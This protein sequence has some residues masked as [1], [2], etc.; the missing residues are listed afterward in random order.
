ME[1]TS[2][3]RPGWLVQLAQWITH[4]GE[5]PP[6]LAASTTRKG[7][8]QMPVRRVTAVH[9]TLQEAARHPQFG[10]LVRRADNLRDERKFPEAE[11]AYK[12]GLNL[13]PLHRGYRVQ[14]AHTLKEQQDCA[15]A[16]AHYCFALAVGAPTFEVEEHLLF[17]ARQTGI[18]VDS[19][20]VERLAS[21]WIAAERTLDDWHVP[22]I[23]SDFIAF[24]RL[25][26]GNAGLVTP[27]L[28]QSCLLRC[29][30]RKELFIYLLGEPATL[31]QNQRLFAILKERAIVNV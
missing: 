16:Y 31:H 10:A 25:I 2:T 27:A 18:E 7:T 30:T 26:W 24:A 28:L 14:Y 5:K 17:S 6:G 21:A 22:P 12:Q 11:A 8:Y 4:R 23:E 9:A 19:N 13:F 20:D 1:A 29:V 15:G 3:E